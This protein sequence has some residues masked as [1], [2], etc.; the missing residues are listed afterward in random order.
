MANTP[1]IDA[2]I[3]ELGGHVSVFMPPKLP[4]YQCNATE[5]QIKAARKRYS[6][7]DFKRTVID[8]GKMPTVQILDFGQN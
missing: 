8:E 4:C 1:W 7:D 6:C 3:Y 5:A 2:G